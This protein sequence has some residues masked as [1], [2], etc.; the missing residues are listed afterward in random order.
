MEFSSKVT[1]AGFNNKQFKSM[2]QRIFIEKGGKSSFDFRNEMELLIFYFVIEGSYIV[3]HKYIKSISNSNDSR[4]MVK[5]V[6]KYDIQ[7]IITDKSNSTTVTLNRISHCFP[8]I[9]LDLLKI[10]P[11]IIK[12]VLPDDAMELAG[13]KYFQPGM[14][15]SA[16]FHIIPHNGA[17]FG[18]VKALLFYNFLEVTELHGRRKISK[19]ADLRMWS[20]INFAKNCYNSELFSDSSKDELLQK[21]LPTIS[22]GVMV[23]WSEKF[24][25]YFYSHSRIVRHIFGNKRI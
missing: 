6:A 4:L 5:L 8:L 7:R 2:L 11:T 13:F 3:D 25:D 18:L 21:Y 22:H 17:Y 19:P 20:V 15:T 12:T 24:D 1:S 14:N 10:N 16:Y 23:S 9:V